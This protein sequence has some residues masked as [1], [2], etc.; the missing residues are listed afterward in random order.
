MFINTFME[1]TSTTP[2]HQI[3]DPD[4]QYVMAGSQ[5]KDPELIKW[6]LTGHDLINE[7]K[8]RLKGDV[9]DEV[10]EKW[11]KETRQLLNDQGINDIIALLNAYGINKNTIL[12]TLNESMV[13]KIMLI[14]DGDLSE[15]FAIN[16]DN[17]ELQVQKMS[18][19]KDAICNQVYFA[20][21]RAIGGAE[22]NFIQSTEQRTYSFSNPMPNQEQKRRTFFGI[23]LPSGR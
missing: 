14:F 17:Y 5:Q 13:F 19:V 11:E 9:Y 8:H 1:F 21:T 12:S 22:K 6:Q 18:L 7:I 16:H 2:Q 23:P 20:M 15:L 10:N 4:S 3:Q